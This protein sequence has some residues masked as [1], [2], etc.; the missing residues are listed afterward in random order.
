[1][2]LSTLGEFGLIGRIRKWTKSSSPKVVQGI[3][4]DVAVMDMGD[5]VLLATT[6][7]L[8]EGIHFEQAW[9]DPFHLGKKALMV[10]LSDIAAMGGIPRYFLVSLGIPKK[11]P[12][13]FTS[14]F[15][16][17]IQ[18]GSKCFGVDLVG[19]DT[20]LSQKIIVN[21]CVLGEGEKQTV[22]FRKGARVGDDLWVSGTLGDSA[23]GLEILQKKRFRGQQKRLAKKSVPTL[24]QREIQGPHGC[25]RKDV[26]G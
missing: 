17:G 26:V 21:V 9:M 19:G 2:D 6:D 3:G 22:L 16:R 12:F 15:Y 10:N 1:M 7:I 24:P 11:L 18:R 23:L 5:R 14:R 8:I 4:D 25:L 20:S 13:L